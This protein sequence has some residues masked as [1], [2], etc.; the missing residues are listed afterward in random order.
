MSESRI[1][2]ALNEARAAMAAAHDAR[3]TIAALL[4]EDPAF[5]MDILTALRASDGDLS[6]AAMDL[7]RANRS[8][9]KADN[10][11]NGRPHNVSPLR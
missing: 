4:V 7:R 3:L 11:E 5:S 10:L 1:T 9:Q 6:N 2:Q 8:L